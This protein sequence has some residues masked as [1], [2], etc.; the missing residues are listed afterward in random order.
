MVAHLKQQKFFYGDAVAEYLP[1]HPYRP[2]RGDY[3]FQNAM[4]QFWMH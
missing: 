4:K 1:I 3:S 2:T